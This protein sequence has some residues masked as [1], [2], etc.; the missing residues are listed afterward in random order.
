MATKTS[1]KTRP[2]RTVLRSKP[3]NLRKNLNGVFSN[4]LSY[5]P[6]SYTPILAALVVIAAFL[7]GVLFTK[8]QYLEK[9][10]AVNINAGSTADTGA[11]TGNQPPAAGAKVDVGVGH[12]PPQGDKNAKV[13]IIEFADLRCPFCEQFFKESE[14]QIIKDYVDS[15]KAVFYFRHFAFLGDASTLA[16]NAT[17]CANEQGK[18][19]EMHDYLYKNQPPESDTSMYTVDNLTQVAGNLGMNTEN[20][21]SCL[22][23]NKYQKNVDKDMSEGQTAGVSGTP[24][25]FVNGVSIVGAVPYAQIKQQIDAALS[26]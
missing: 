13:K 11:T 6:K 15:G 16:A 19:W 20:F 23:T 4:A 10:Q 22:S 3:Q 9:G 5:R 26:Q 21:R 14:P 12:F 18:F 17:E 8:I 2:V 24:T 7:I 25:L 1:A